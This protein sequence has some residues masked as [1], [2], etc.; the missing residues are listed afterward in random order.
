MRMLPILV[1]SA[2]LVVS[3]PIAAGQDPHTQMNHR[4][5]HAM[6]FDQDKTTHHFYL[7][8]DGGAI[9]ISVKDTKDTTNRDAIRSHL[10]HIATMFGEGNFDIPMFV[11]DSHAVPGTKALAEHKSHIQ[12]S[13]VETPGGGLVNIVAR[14]PEARAAIHEFLKFQITEHKTGDPTTVRKRG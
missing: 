4:G 11:H 5:A 7:Y 9:D 12:Y 10:P 14:D 1:A 13:Y 8:D 2:L 6:G 3:V